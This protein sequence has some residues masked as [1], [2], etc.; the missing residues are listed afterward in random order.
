MFGLL[1]F[2]SRDRLFDV[3][4]TEFFFFF[5]FFFL[6]YIDYFVVYLKIFE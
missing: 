5:F 6:N 4:G 1:G 3:R 2:V